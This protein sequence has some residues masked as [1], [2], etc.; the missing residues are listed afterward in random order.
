MN[1][2]LEHILVAVLTL[3][4]VLL[5]GHEMGWWGP[6]RVHVIFTP[7][8][9]SPQPE[10]STPLVQTENCTLEPGE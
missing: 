5:L 1:K 8:T 7:D 9:E 2:I 3:L 4:V 6:E 10:P